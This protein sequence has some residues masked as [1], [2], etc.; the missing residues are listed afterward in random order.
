M[1]L[2]Y[3]GLMVEVHPNPSCALSDA[4]QQITPVQFAGLL[5]QLVLRTPNSSDVD[6]IHILEELRA[7]VN[8]YDEKIVELFKPKNG[9]CKRNR[10]L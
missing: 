9:D 5:D 10:S 3:D 6:F 1:D 8:N 2:D 7:K 4:K